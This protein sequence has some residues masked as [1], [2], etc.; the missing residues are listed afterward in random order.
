MLRASAAAAR[1]AARV[2]AAGG[3]AA[4]PTETVYGLACRLTPDAAR[5][6]F[7][8]KG[9]PADNPLIVHVLDEAQL[10][11]VARRVTPLARRLI[12][13]FWPGPLTLVLARGPAVPRAVTAGRDTVAVRMPS[14]PAARAVLRA[15]GAPFAAPSANRSGRPSPT[16]AAHVRRDL[17]ARVPLILDGGPCREG[18]ESTVVDARGRAPVLLRPGTVTLEALGRVARSAARAPGRGAPPSPGTRH[19]HYAP[20]CRVVPVSPAA[21]RAGRI[22][23]GAGLLHRSPW[24]GGRVAHRSRVAGGAAAYGRAFFAALRAAEA[25]RV[26]VLA[27]E[28]VPET[29]VGRAVMDRLRRAAA[30]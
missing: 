4:V 7:R 30:R 25:A 21:V 17:G 1:E 26:K 6:V 23:A 19:R 5:R 15:L 18:L 2:L 28:T 8:A 9:R 13:A 29:G 24:G 10:R 12:D 27:V 3:L 14:H 16:T 22:P 20:A 11:L